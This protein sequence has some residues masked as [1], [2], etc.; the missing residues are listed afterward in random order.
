MASRYDTTPTFN[1]FYQPVDLNLVAQVG[2][3]REAKY[4]EGVQKVQSYVDKASS[5]DLIKDADKNYYASK[6]S[7]LSD[8]I[9]DVASQDFSNPTLQSTVGGLA[10]SILKDKNIQNAYT[11]TQKVRQKQAMIKEIRTKNPELYNPANE[12][13]SMLDVNEWLN[14][15]TAGT[16]LVDNKSYYNYYDYAKEVREA[17]NGF[18]PSKI[19]RKTPQ[20]EWIVTT[21]DASWTEGELR[22]YL[23]GVLSDRAKQQLKVEGVT[24]FYGKDSALLSGYYS[25]MKDTVK[26]NNST[27]SALQA[28]LAALGDP[29]QK[30]IINDKI[31]SLKE[32]NIDYIS[33]TSEIDDGNLDFFN[34]NKEG[35]AE[36]LMK[37]GYISGVIS[38]YSHVDDTV[39]YSPNDIW[40]A[41]F[42]ES[43]DNAR[44]NAR[45]AFDAQQSALG[46]AFT[47]DENEKNRANQRT[48]KLMD[49]GLKDA[50]GNDIP[51]FQKAQHN[52]SDKDKSVTSKDRFDTEV[53]TIEVKSAEQYQKL[54]NEILAGDDNLRRQ[55]INFIKGGGKSGSKNDPVEIA[56]NEF[57]RAQMSKPKSERNPIADEYIEQ[58]NALNME[59]EV[60]DKKRQDIDNQVDIE[61]A[62]LSAKL[63]AEWKSLPEETNVTL[64]DSRTGK[65]EPTKVSKDQLRDIML[66][67]NGKF[68]GAPPDPKTKPNWVTKEPGLGGA[69]TIN[70]NGKQISFSPGIGMPKQYESLVRVYNTIASNN[71]ELAKIA[72][73]KNGLYDQA[74]L[75]MGDWYTPT[76][77]K[78]PSVTAAINF[79][80]RNYGGTPDEWEVSQVNR[81]TGDVQFR[82]N[83]KNKKNT[84]INETLLRGAS[85]Y[86]QVND[87]YT[88]KGLSYFVRKG[89]DNLSP[90]DRTMVKALEVNNNLPLQGYY[91]PSGSWDPN[92]NGQFLQILKKMGSDG[93]YRYYLRHEDSKVIINQDLADPVSAV[94]AG[95]ALTSDLN[96]LQDII[97]KQ[98]KNYTIKSN[99]N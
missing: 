84:T 22:E 65:Y 37:D 53:K 60:Y 74:L 51:Q 34:A 41:K 75:N 95:K 7:E 9:R 17:M 26:S 98:E 28:R 82:L 67:Q 35:I 30:A 93:Q 59:R 66:N 1:P 45:M 48:L 54:R 23:N 5:L 10:N 92:G 52:L 13:Y 44:A 20:G 55:N 12:A 97:R 80:Q 69:Y 25:K 24:A 36:Y 81:T 2:F 77:T 16:P 90:T 47:A 79:M 64:Y 96:M 63:A 38:G 15:G 70:I 39:E 78:D 4:L 85:E 68:R 8:N 6:L 62:S 99:S 50:N 18:K 56:T 88:Y 73:F 19:R 11:G 86:D 32:Q 58:Q 83:P 42:Q 40:K 46:R 71:K 27:I 87:S 3:T 61:M 31:N 21:E 94:N 43:M 76:S 89:L 91:T 49:L 72:E 57:V 29:V 33:K 14:D